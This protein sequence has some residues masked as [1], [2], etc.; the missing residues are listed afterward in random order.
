[1]KSAT[2]A[3]IQDGAVAAGEPTLGPPGSVT[4]G[5]MDGN[6]TYINGMRDNLR[7]LEVALSCN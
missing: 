3:S 1:M 2:A 5:K 4:L 7:I 6:A